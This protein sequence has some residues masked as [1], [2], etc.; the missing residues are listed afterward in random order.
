MQFIINAAE[1]TAT[2]QLIRRET[3]ARE[4]NHENQAIPELQA[5]LDGFENFHSMQ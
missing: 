3:K 5:P 2:L 4:H 1:R